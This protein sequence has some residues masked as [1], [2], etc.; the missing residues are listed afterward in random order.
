MNALR[1]SLA[2]AGFALLA[3]LPLV[4]AE[5]WLHVAT[6]ILIFGLF[7]LSFNIIYGYM[8]QIT[9]GHAAFFGI[10]AYT[11]AILTR[12]EL[13][14]TGTVSWT[15]FL[16]AI[17]AAPVVAAAVAMVAGWFCVR[18][19]G[20]YFAIL[21]LAFGELFYYI[22]FSWYSFTGGDNG[23]QGLRP[24]EALAATTPYYYFAVA[25]VGAAVFVMWRIT[26]S[27]FGYTLRAMRDDTRRVSFLGVNVKLHQ[28]LAFVVAAG[29]AGLAGA[30]W[31]PFS[32]SVAPALLGWQKSGEAVFATLI[33]GA[34][35]FLGPVLGAGVF[36]GLHAWITEFTQ[37]WPLAIG[38]IILLLV[39]FLPGGLL[40]LVPI[41][42]KRTSRAED[43]T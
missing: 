4:V 29:F 1:L 37:Y 31:G 43:R 14:E 23:I 5:F 33:G 13:A 9:F 10:G 16:A 19:T 18:L 30:L 20:I 11:T 24:P 27:P 39:L 7:A 25:V 8:G 34:N 2:A 40:S 12:G 6:E 3:L 17:A 38:T 15:L 22:V 26:R 21:T 35:Y 28:W 42:G 32:R 36:I 41:A